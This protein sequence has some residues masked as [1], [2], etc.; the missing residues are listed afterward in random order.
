M[1]TLVTLTFLR[2][3]TRYDPFNFLLKGRFTQ[4][5]GTYYCG[6]ANFFCTH[7]FLRKLSSASI[8][9]WC[10]TV[11][12]V[13]ISVLFAKYKPNEDTFLRTKTYK[14]TKFFVIV[15]KSGF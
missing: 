9:I 8:F 13:W 6:L 14:K 2:L 3:F 12:V 1:V 4:Y 7:A 5:T 15:Y 10:F 11:N